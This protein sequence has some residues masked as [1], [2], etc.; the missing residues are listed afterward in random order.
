MLF[1]NEALPV[2]PRIG[3][4]QSET[5]RRKNVR[6]Q[7]TLTLVRVFIELLRLGLNQ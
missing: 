3:E 4:K 1:E 5:D 2:C 6:Y 7:K